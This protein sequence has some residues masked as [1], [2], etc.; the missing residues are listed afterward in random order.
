MNGP[1]SAFNV[2]IPTL[3]ESIREVFRGKGPPSSFLLWAQS[4]WSDF[5]MRLKHQSPTTLPRR[6]QTPLR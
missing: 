2:R 1:E 6:W 4:P 5:P 3:S